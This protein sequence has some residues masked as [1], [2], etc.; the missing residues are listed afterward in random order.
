MKLF[1]LILLGV[2]AFQNSES[3]ARDF[4]ESETEL[5]L[6]KTNSLEYYVAP[7]LGSTSTSNSNGS[8]NRDMHFTYGGE[9][10][11]FYSHFGLDL[12]ASDFSSGKTGNESVSVSEEDLWLGTDLKFKFLTEGVSPY[13]SI[14]AGEIFETVQTSVLGQNEKMSG[15]DF[16]GSVGAGLFTHFSQYFGLDISGKYFQY[17]NISGFSYCLSFGFYTVG[18]LF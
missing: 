7:L 14:G 16:I 12:K 5:P 9:A 10:D 17:S 1:I 11:I 4:P 6:K 15:S 8:K 2:V 3:Q 18:S 13:I